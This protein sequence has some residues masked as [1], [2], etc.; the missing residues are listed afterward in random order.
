MKYFF[1]SLALL[2]V[3][4]YISWLY[5]WFPFTGA[6]KKQAQSD[7]DTLQ[8]APA[9]T[10]ADRILVFSPHPDDESLSCGGTISKALA[11]GAQ[12]YICWMC[13]GDGF[14]LDAKLLKAEHELPGTD[15][16][17][18]LMLALGN[19]RLQEAHNAGDSLGLAADHLFFMGYGDGTIAPMFLYPDS[20][21]TSPYTQKNTGP[22]ANTIS[23]NQEY[24]G[25]NAEKNIHSLIDSLRPT[26]VYA[27]AP[28]DDQVD[29]AHTGM[30][31]IK[32]L[33]SL[34]KLDLM[35]NYIVHG[36]DYNIS[37]GNISEY[38]I[39]HGLHKDMALNQP[40]LAASKSY[41]WTKTLL[42]PQDESTKY[43]AIC[44]HVS[45]MKIMSGFLEAFVRTN[46]LYAVLD[47]S[48]VILPRQY[49]FHP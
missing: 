17:S 6:E 7:I 8:V 15:T 9:F 14:E 13:T 26:I 23:F 25:R 22:Y 41:R 11:A 46:E 20:L 43:A 1:S 39:P 35:R 28:I 47:S 12:V 4:L 48:Q 31:V 30:F 45:Q 42:S 36:G 19:L 10:N 38:P 29:H 5:G 27:P 49:Y 21:V 37:V 24:R 40:V 34:G 32:A 18:V 16:L 44:A 33:Q 2:T 3:Y